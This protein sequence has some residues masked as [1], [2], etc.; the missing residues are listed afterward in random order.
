MFRHLETFFDQLPSRHPLLWN[1]RLP[2][3]ALPLAFLHLLFFAAGYFS[4]ELKQLHEYNSILEIGGPLLYL[5]SLLLTIVLLLIWLLHYLRINAFKQYYPLPRGHQFLQWSAIFFIVLFSASFHE[6]FHAGSSAKIRKLIP[7]KKLVADANT[8]NLAAGFMGTDLGNYFLLNG[9]DSNLY[10]DNVDQYFRDTKETG[11]S[12]VEDSI[13]WTRIW[14]VAQQPGALSLANYCRNEYALT[15]Y[16]GLRTGQENSEIRMRWYLNERYDSIQWLLN[17][18]KNLLDEHG[19]K[20]EFN[21]DSL[22]H[23]DRSEEGLLKAL[24]VNSGKNYSYD[25][26]N[27]HYNLQRSIWELKSALNLADGRYLED[28]HDDDREI[29]WVLLGYACLCLSIFIFTYRLF[30]R[31]IFLIG[32][33]A[34][35]VY[36][37]LVGAF[38][39]VDNDSLDSFSYLLLFF[40]LLAVL[41][42]AVT[43]NIRPFP[44]EAAGVF[45]LLTSWSIWFVIPVTSSL[46]AD[47]YD[48]RST[49]L[50][51]A[52]GMGDEVVRQLYP[53]SAWIH[54]HPLLIALLNILF[55]FLLIGYILPRFARQSHAQPEER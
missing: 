18:V 3:M 38:L 42:F 49:T 50:F 27:D 33:F 23:C 7:V 6:S 15:K 48:E 24:K 45:L 43:R 13:H 37:I 26:G 21:W 5:F 11:F 55:V 25:Y 30:T 53:V 34:S 44:K 52:Q 9:C 54:S 10:L 39:S 12:S 8:L 19:L 4:L 46:I 29:T 32:I 41:G 47:A 2:H 36:L 22:A 17:G 40:C 1:L 16:T 35:V 51:Q 14:A 20:S 31:R 28:L